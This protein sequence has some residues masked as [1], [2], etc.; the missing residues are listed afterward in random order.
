MNKMQK[1]GLS[2]ALALAL[3]FS[4]LLVF[5]L[6]FD[7]EPEVVTQKPAPEIIQASV[8]DD[9]QVIQEAERLKQAEVE[10]QQLKE[11]RRQELAEQRAAEEKRLQ[12]VRERRLREEKKAKELVERRKQAEE[13][14]RQ[15]QADLKKQLVEEAARL[16]K[17]KEQRAAEQKRL[18]AQREA[19]Q[20]RIE[21][22][23]AAAAKKREQERLAEEK[24]KQELLAKQKAEQARREELARQQAEAAKA[25]AEQDRQATITATAAIQ[26][27]V[28]NS[29]IRPMTSS[30]GLSCTVQVKLL[31]S[32][33]VMD[34]SVVK[35]SGDSVFDRSA[36]NAVRKA[37]P[38]P[39]PKD[40]TLFSRNF[41]TFTF[42][43]K[44]E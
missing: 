34:A 23:K 27:K 44:P 40:R 24:R 4:L 3:H 39:V 13:K 1:F 20:K 2:F 17:I 41:R 29:W 43:F 31:A 6:S 7:S 11:K 21:A 12:Q 33:D 16:A 26:R 5:G 19:E 8:L 38:L 32:G 36:E 37:S 14:E 18:K 30:K 15:K 25:K 35:S 9:E 28:N 42:V 22:E 10:K